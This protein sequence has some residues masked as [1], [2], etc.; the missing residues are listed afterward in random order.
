VDDA[1]V[2]L[3]VDQQRVDR[4]AAV[5][6]RDVAD[7]LHLARLRVDVDHARVRAERATEVLGS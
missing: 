1:A 7:D 6:D 3:A 5:V 2:D 4:R